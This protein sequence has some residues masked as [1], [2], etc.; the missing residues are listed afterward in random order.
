MAATGHE[1]AREPV[2]CARGVY[3]PRRI[4]VRWRQASQSH[5]ELK[6]YMPLI[7]E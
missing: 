3:T 6:I 4:G 7:G 1:H 5:K 2:S